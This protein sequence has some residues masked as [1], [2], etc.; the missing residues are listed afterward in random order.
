[1]LQL[2]AFEPIVFSSAEA[3]K[4]HTDFEQAVCVILDINL[5][6]GSGIDLR[7]RL[8]AKDVSVP[9]IY[10]TGNDDPA[11]REAA[12]KSGCIAFL[13]KPFS[14]KELINSLGTLRPQC[15]HY[16]HFKTSPRIMLDWASL[17][18]SPVLSTVRCVDP[19]Q[20]VGLLPGADRRLLPLAGDFDFFQANLQLGCLRLVIVRR[21]PCASEGYL[22][23][24]QTG[25][26][27][28]MS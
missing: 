18:S 20:I 6:D 25:I 24:D 23:P 2:H 14:A 26:A 3:F 16:A 21:P 4:R 7:Y 5:N 9:V 8:K 19:E 22:E 17:S 28:P 15:L 12:L 27:L 13:S 1:M 11:V 10:M